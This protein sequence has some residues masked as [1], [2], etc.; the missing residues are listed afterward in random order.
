MRYLRCIVVLFVAGCFVFGPLIFADEI[1]GLEEIYDTPIPSEIR[2][3]FDEYIHVRETCP[4]CEQGVLDGEEFVDIYT[5]KF[6]VI[7][8]YPNGFGGVWAVI[9]VEG[10]P[11]RAFRLWLYDINPD[12]YDLRSVAELKGSFEEDAMR[13]LCSSAYSHFWL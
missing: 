6:I 11:L 3:N 12:E 8:F 1:N 10:V 4:E 13:Q 2:R 7:G 5:K 9:A